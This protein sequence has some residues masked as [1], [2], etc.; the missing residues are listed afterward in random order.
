[1][2]DEGGGGWARGLDRLRIDVSVSG[3]GVGKVKAKS[4]YV[5][6]ANHGTLSTARLQW[7]ISVGHIWMDV[8]V[9]HVSVHTDQS[10]LCLTSDE[11]N[12]SCY[13]SS[14]AFLVT[15]C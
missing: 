13:N 9:T 8:N 5:K 2:L 12:S 1:M 11:K 6:R 7:C 4:A 14:L 10:A 3:R 15:L